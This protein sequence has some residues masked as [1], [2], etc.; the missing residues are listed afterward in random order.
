[1]KKIGKRGEMK[2]TPIKRKSKSETAKLKEEIQ[3]LLREIVIK[4][5]G[6]CIRCNI[7]VGTGGVIFQADHLITRSNSATYA[8]SRLV[9]CVCRNC[10]YWKSVGANSRK[11]QY[12]DLVKKKISK[13]R[14]KLWERCEKESWQPKSTR[15][16]D[17]KLH[18][19]A[20][21]QELE[22]LKGWG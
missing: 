17:W 8:D 6:K 21:S 11:N 14:V 10:H 2:R 22:R 20:L 1:M 15:A 19:L 4:R 3:R 9:V 13:E 7:P 16:N 5:D 12:D 18:I